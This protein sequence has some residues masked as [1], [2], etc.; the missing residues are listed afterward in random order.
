MPSP[1]RRDLTTTLLA[2]LKQMLADGELHPTD[3]LPPERDLARHFGVNR[4]SLRQALKALEIIGVLRQRVGDGTY[5]TED[6]SETLNAPLDFLL[7]IDGITFGELYEA[8]R[9][10]EPE[11][12]A[13]AARRHTGQEIAQLEENVAEMKRQLEAGFLP[14]IATCD[15]RFHL[16]IWQMAGNRVCLRMLAPFHR[17]MTNN[18]ALQ[19]SIAEYAIAVASHSD[20]LQAIRAGDPER[21]R[22]CMNEH[23]EQAESVLGSAVRQ[24]SRSRGQPTSRRLSMTNS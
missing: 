5:L 4:A 8:R 1:L 22:W 9:V 14:G 12:A 16:L 3:K 7:L 10:F 21:A 6:A 2:G 24:S 11:L 17:T 15:Q 18:F 23:L 13:R 20:I 19:W